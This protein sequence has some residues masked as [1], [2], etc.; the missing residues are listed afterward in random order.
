[1]DGRQER[2]NIIANQTNGNQFRE[3]EVIIPDGLRGRD[4]DPR[5][6]V[7]G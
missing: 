4:G 3:D 1:M 5:V 2:R 6:T 7:R